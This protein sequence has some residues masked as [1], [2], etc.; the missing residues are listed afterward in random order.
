VL[1]SS[2]LGTMRS[3]SLTSSTSVSKA[4][5]GSV[6]GCSSLSSCRRDTVIRKDP[7]AYAS[8]GAAGVGSATARILAPCR[9]RGIM[10]VRPRRNLM[11]LT[12]RGF[13]R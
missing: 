9:G 11:T 3:W 13:C 5:S 12:P 7:N 6:T 4:F 1:S 10:W 2:S 8:I